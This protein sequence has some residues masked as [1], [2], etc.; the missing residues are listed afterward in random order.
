MDGISRRRFLRTATAGGV[1]A[2]TGILFGLRSAWAAAAQASWANLSPGFT[3]LITQYMLA[4]KLDE[5]NGVQFGTPINYTSVGTFYQDFIAGR[6]D[7]CMGT[8]DTFAAR[9]LAGV[10]I[11][12][13]CTITT[14]DMINIIAPANGPNNVKE[15]AG[16]TVAALQS[17]GTYRLTKALIKEYN[18]IDL[19]AVATVQNV[20][21]P[22][23]AVTLVMADRA[24]AGLSWEPN[25][26]SAL[27]RVPTLKV[28]YNAGVEYRA[29]TGLD[30]PFFGVAIRKELSARDPH[31]ARNINRAFADCLAGI[32]GN[33]DEAVA[34]GGAGTGIP[35]DVLKLAISSGRLVFKHGSMTDAAA[36]KS[37]LTAAD[38]LQRNGLLPKK[39]DD[40]FFAAS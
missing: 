34:I 21:N 19:E 7:V 18:G 39:L 33:V 5:K 30:L 9:Y 32:V 27:K 1:A 31:I 15:L 40:A 10:P 23:A 2:A 3:I 25:I 28:I 4:K 24:D 16:K 35:A 36:R 6:Y 13:V 12:L 17:S 20:D 29:K 22:A 8:W 37:I 26:S 38:L 14:G 11:E